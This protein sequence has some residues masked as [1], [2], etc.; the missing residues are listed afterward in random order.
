MTISSPTSP[1][2]EQYEDYI[3]ATLRALGYFIETRIILRDQKK[4]VL[5][6]DIVATPVGRSGEERELYE[7]KK[8]GINFSNLFKLY[9]QRL[10]LGIERACL[11]SLKDAHP[12]YR[13]A[14]ETKGNEL[15]I[16]VR[17]QVVDDAAGAGLARAFNALDKRQLE[18]VAGCAW[19]LQI[20]KRLALAS[21]NRRC[22]KERGSEYFS[23]IKQYNFDVNASF[24]GA[25][26]LARAEALYDAYRERPGLTGKGVAL[27]AGEK[28]VSEKSIWDATQSSHHHLWLQHLMLL[29]GTA[30]IAIVKNA[31]DDLLERRDS[32]LPTRTVNFAGSEVNL[33]L[34][35]LPLRYVT[36]L[37]ILRDHPYS[38]QLPY[39]YQCFLELLGGFLF[40]EDEEELSFLEALTGVPA[41]EVVECIELLDHFFAPDGGSFFYKIKGQI[42]SLKMVPGI[43]RG[44]GCFLRKAV[45]DLNEYTDRYPGR[46]WL[47]GKWHNCAYFALEQELGESAS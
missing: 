24:F 36:G 32:S 44:I 47:L 17:C 22:A 25:S 37:E 45:F 7:V 19:F 3:S 12:D 26:A 4:E 15:G 31:L 39:L 10:Y 8:A 42:L 1:T 33:P 41:A 40:F 23:E 46:G 5:E 13:A 11:V 28:G 6:L 9:G 21:M 43:V 20:V 2:G 27:V 30:R 34:H 38:L 14:Y 16:R 29:E 35:D 18:A